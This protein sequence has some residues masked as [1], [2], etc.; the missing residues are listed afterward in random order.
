VAATLALLALSA[1]ATP[2]QV[3]ARCERDVRASSSTTVGGEF[4]MG[5]GSDYGSNTRFVSD[6]DIA[7][8]AGVN[9]GGGPADPRYAYEECVRERTGQGPVRPY[10][11]AG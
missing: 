2:E 4:A 9:L 3:A 1:C 6:A 5:V 7:L 11:V 8:S 10:G